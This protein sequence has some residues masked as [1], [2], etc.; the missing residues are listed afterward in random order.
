LFSCEWEVNNSNSF[1]PVICKSLKC[2]LCAHPI[3]WHPYRNACYEFLIYFRP[4]FVSLFYKVCYFD[5]FIVNSMY[6]YMMAI[7]WKC[8]NKLDV[9]IVQNTTSLFGKVLFN[10]FYQIISPNFNSLSKCNLK[11]FLLFISLLSVYLNHTIQI[12]RLCI[13]PI[14]L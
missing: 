2:A 13:K 3:N 4:L 11:V 8:H 10:L 6:Y 12:L 7:S 9:I 14:S 1:A 5:H